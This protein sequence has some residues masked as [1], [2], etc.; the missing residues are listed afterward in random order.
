[1]G[2]WSTWLG[3]SHSLLAELWCRL[4]KAT[5]ALTECSHQEKSK[6]TE[7]TA[8]HCLCH[9]WSHPIP[10]AC[11][12]VSWAFPLSLMMRL[13]SGD[14]DASLP[15]GGPACTPVFSSPCPCCAIENEASHSSRQHEKNAIIKWPIVGK[16]SVDGFKYLS[17]VWPLG[18]C[19]QSPL[20]LCLHISLKRK[21]LLQTSENEQCLG[22]SMFHTQHKRTESKLADHA[23]HQEGNTPK[24]WPWL[25][26]LARIYRKK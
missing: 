24:C 5:Q 10:V 12:L 23:D 18:A 26:G 7:F 13:W 2:W 4:L 16:A 14:E 21:I 1:M 3:V 11:L 9:G 25:F 19:L 15:L 8:H 6:Y 17:P 20:S 22:S